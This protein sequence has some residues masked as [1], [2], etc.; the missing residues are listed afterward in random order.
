MPL[1]TKGQKTKSE[2]YYKPRKRKVISPIQ[3]SENNSQTK[4]SDNQSSS[5]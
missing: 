5:Q 1:K 2:S 3:T 4:V